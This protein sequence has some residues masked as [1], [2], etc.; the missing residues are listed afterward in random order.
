MTHANQYDD[1]PSNDRVPWEAPKAVRGGVG[2]VR[3]RTDSGERGGVVGTIVVRF[4]TGAT[5]VPIGVRA[6]VTRA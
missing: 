5:M 6:P 4:A 3:H 1:C 2:S